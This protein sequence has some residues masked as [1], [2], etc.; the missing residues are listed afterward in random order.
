M[1]STFGELQSTLASMVD[2]KLSDMRDRVAT[3]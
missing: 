2:R 1:E 3:E